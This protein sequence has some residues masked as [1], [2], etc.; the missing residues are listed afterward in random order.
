MKNSKVTTQLGAIPLPSNKPVAKK[1]TAQSKKEIIWNFT[2]PM[3]F[4]SI[5]IAERLLP[6]REMKLLSKITA[7]VAI[8]PPDG[9]R[10]SKIGPENSLM[11]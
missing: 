2:L 11:P 6:I 9:F 5:T 3:D 7:F 10:A 4:M 1:S 8:R